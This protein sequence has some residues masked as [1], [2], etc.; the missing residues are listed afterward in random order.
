[1][2]K[3]HNKVL[4]LQ[5]PDLQRSNGYKSLTCKK[6][7]ARGTIMIVAVRIVRHISPLPLVVIIIVVLHTVANQLAV[8]YI[9][10]PLKGSLFYSE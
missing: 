7:R 4:R 5:E 3:L 1:M 9:P 10:E 2:A 6:I 8:V